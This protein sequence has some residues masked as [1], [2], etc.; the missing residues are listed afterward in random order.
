MNYVKFD[1]NQKKIKFTGYTINL[2]LDDNITAFIGRINEDEDNNLYLLCWDHVILAS[3]P[4]DVY[5]DQTFIVERFIDIEIKEKT[6]EEGII[7]ENKS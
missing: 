4:G 5:K 2:Y 1:N 6:L 7:Y 3:L